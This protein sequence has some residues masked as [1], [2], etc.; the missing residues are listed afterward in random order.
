MFLRCRK[1]LE[2]IVDLGTS[3]VSKGMLLSVVGNIVIYITAI[4]IE[5]VKESKFE[6]NFLDD[7]LSYPTNY[8][9]LLQYP[10]VLILIDFAKFLLLFPF[11]CIAYCLGKYDYNFVSQ[12][13]DWSYTHL[14]HWQ[15]QD[16]RK[17]N[18]YCE[19]ER[20]FLLTQIFDRDCCQVINSYMEPNLFFDEGSLL[21]LQKEKL[22]LYKNMST[23]LNKSHL[24][25][26]MFVYV[27][28]FFLI[29]MYFIRP[30][31]T[32]K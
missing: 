22:K 32:F 19:A 15:R 21:K 17:C 27:I 30:R 3:L 1:P 26:D 6:Y 12:F 7:F 16:L 2:L 29:F 20:K 13:Y 5:W 11:F 14:Y 31:I 4:F 23:C 10:M 28:S 18:V 8:F 25:F 24:F 9:R